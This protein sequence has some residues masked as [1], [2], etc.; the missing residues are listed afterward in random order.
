MK[1]KSRTKTEVRTVPA[2]AFKATCLALLDEV[3]R[4]E[5]RLVVTKRGKAVAEVRAPQAEPKP[6]RSVVGRSPG[7]KAPSLEEWAKMK[8]ELIQDM[9]K[10]TARLAEML[11]DDKVGKRKRA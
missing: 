8:A 6:F 2:G 9:D 5:V 4:G 11:Q 10:S 3:E 1:A 7:I